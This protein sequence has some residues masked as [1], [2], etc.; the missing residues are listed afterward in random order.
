MS[1]NPNIINNAE[2]REPQVEAYIEVHRHFEITK[3]KSNALV[4]LPTG[5]GK[6]GLMGILPYFISR[7]RVLIVTP[8]VSIKDTVID[9]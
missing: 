4:V 6:T 9:N 3:K 1:S 5:V 8:Q 7:G 2:L